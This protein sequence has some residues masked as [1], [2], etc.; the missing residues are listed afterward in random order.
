MNPYSLLQDNGTA[1][2]TTLLVK[3][4]HFTDGETEARD[5]EL[6]QGPR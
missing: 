4:S 1:L 3:H 2:M 6:A 5:G